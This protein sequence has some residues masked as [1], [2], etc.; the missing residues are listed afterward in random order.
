MDT[1]EAADSHAQRMDRMYRIQRHV[2]DATRKYYLL[3]RDRTIRQMDAKPG[4]RV[5]ELGCGTGRNLKLVA[6]T[7]PGVTVCGLDISRKM[8]SS[9]RKTLSKAYIEASLVAGDATSFTPTDFGHDGFDHILLSYSLSM[10]PK[11]Q[12]TIANAVT[13]LSPGGVLHIV[14][15]GQQEN[16]PRWFSR[17]LFA[18]LKAFEVT[19]RQDLRETIERIAHASNSN[20][21]FTPLYAGYTWQAKIQKD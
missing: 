9:A 7:F 18:W 6:E 12:D 19:P 3:G 11:W 16:L 20:W 17:L 8:L 2:Y 21:Q 13:A 10:I 5:L 15:F 14:D 1:A 4:A